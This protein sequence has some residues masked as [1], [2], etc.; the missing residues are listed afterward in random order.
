MN[1]VQEKERPVPL[2]K[3]VLGYPYAADSSLFKFD[4]SL[5]YKLPD[6]LRKYSNEKPVLVAQ[7]NFSIHRTPFL[8]CC[9]LLQIFCSSRKG[10]Q[11]TASYL[12][13]TIFSAGFPF[14]L[15]QKL[16]DVANTLHDA[17]LKGNLN[18]FPKYPFFKFQIRGDRKGNQL[19][20]CGAKR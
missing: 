18:T 19:S 16:F 17:K 15:R 13:K 5:N 7:K 20:S 12:A 11:Q 14:G 9:I 2:Q 1:R 8:Q 3:I 4:I 6:L 10:A